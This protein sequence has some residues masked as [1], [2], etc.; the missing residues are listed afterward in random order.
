[1]DWK[2]DFYSTKDLD[3]NRAS[4]SN[5]AD[6]LAS[7]LYKRHLAP[8]ESQAKTLPNNKRKHPPKYSELE[9]DI[10]LDEVELALR[11]VKHIEALEPDGSVARLYI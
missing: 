7:S 6:A 8:K 11:T 10:T 3:S 4:L 5:K 9:S 1:M 2:P